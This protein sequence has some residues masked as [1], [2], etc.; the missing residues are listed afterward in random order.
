MSSMI[1]LNGVIKKNLRGWAFYHVFIKNRC[2]LQPED[3][4]GFLLP[5]IWKV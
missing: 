4:T 2:H 1:K 5:S 3:G